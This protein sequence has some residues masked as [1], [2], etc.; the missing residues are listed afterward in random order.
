ML[1]TE[2]RNVGVVDQVAGCARCPDDLLKN[3][4]VTLGF[5]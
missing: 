2:R 4:I 3:S 5:R 1:E